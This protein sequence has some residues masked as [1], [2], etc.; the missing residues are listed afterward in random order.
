M[1]NVPRISFSWRSLDASIADIPRGAKARRC[2]QSLY[3][4]IPWVDSCDANISDLPSHSVRQS[5]DCH[6]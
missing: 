6:R 2:N 3:R 5:A 1:H 4:A